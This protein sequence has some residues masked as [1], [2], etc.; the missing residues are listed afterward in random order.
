MKVAFA[1][2]GAKMTDAQKAALTPALLV[3]QCT[4]LHHGDYVGASSEAHDIAAALNYDIVIHP[5]RNRLYPWKRAFKVSDRVIPEMDYGEQQAKMVEDTDC[6]IVASAGNS[7]WQSGC[8]LPIQIARKLGKK[9][10]IL[11]PSGKMKVVR[12]KIARR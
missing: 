6:L 5:N 12:A 8:W 9:I 1:A 3:Q 10:A 2:T 11:Y 7:Q 4:E